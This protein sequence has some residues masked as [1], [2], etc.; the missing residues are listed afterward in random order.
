MTRLV[1]EAIHFDQLREHGGLVGLRDE[2]ALEAALARSRHKWAYRRKADLAAL[3]AAYG[4]DLAR[5]HP[6]HDGNKRVALVTML[7]FLELNNRHFS[8]PEED[9]VRTMTGVAAGGVSEAALVSWIRRHVVGRATSALTDC[10]SVAGA[11][12]RRADNAGIASGPLALE[13]PPPPQAPVGPP[14]PSTG[15]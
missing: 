12:A 5:G 2:G 3:A 4:Y 11:Y 6:F 15:S 8:A 9:V 7:V 14:G 1:V 10:A 13:G